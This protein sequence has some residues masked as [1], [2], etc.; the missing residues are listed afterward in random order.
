MSFDRTA[1]YKDPYLFFS[2]NGNAVMKLEVDAAIQL[3]DLALDFD[4]MIARVEGGIW[5]NP[6][7]ESRLDCIWD[8]SHILDEQPE[9]ANK[10]AKEFIKEE[11]SEHNAFII[12]TQKIVK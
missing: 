6:G 9:K 1:C 12:T 5:H 7:F 8:R 2:L 3:C 11:S 4:C 10:S